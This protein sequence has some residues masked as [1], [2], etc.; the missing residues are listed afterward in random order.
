MCRTDQLHVP[1]VWRTEVASLLVKAFRQGRINDQERLEGSKRADVLAETA[2]M[3]AE[4]GI[5]DLV[6]LAQ[7][8]SLRAHDATYLR[9]A[10]ELRLPL[11]T[12]DRAL[13]RAAPDMGVPLLLP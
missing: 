13:M 6:A 8:C 3:G 5:A 10:M 7:S 1:P 4:G 11:L 12:N 9:L 2:T